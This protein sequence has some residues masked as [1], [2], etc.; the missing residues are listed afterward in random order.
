GDLVQRVEKQPKAVKFFHAEVKQRRKNGEFY[1]EAMA[2]VA[3]EIRS[4]K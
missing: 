2:R 3:G 1:S 4:G